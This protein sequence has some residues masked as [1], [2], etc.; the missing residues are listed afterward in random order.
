MHQ[1]KKYFLVL[2]N[3]Q[4]DEKELVAIAES[5]I[6]EVRSGSATTLSALMKARDSFS[7]LV[8]ASSGGEATKVTTA[9]TGVESGRIEAII[10]L[11]KSNDRPYLS[12]ET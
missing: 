4:I 3:I 5:T 8:L 11:V 9:F 6:R 2:Q 10:K 7:E 12:G 1:D